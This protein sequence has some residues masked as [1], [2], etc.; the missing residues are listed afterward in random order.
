MTYLDFVFY[1]IVASVTSD[2]YCSESLRR[3]NSYRKWQY[4]IWG[5]C[6]FQIGPY[7]GIK[8]APDILVVSTYVVLYVKEA[9]VN[10]RH[11]DVYT[12]CWYT[13]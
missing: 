12:G 7:K 3:L 5:G 4:Y 13:Y 10:T 2:V 8:S 9:A 11:L 6:V 1:N